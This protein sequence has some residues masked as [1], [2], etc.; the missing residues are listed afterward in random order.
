[1]LDADDIQQKTLTDT[2]YA[3]DLVILA[4]TPTQAESLLQNLNIGWLIFEHRLR[5]R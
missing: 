4:N 5:D 1:M 2:N 3:V